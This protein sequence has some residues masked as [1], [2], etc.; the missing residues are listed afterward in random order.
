MALSLLS[1]RPVLAGAA[2]ATGRGR[3]AKGKVRDACARESA[4]LLAR[5]R[6]AARSRAWSCKQN[7]VIAILRAILREVVHPTNNADAHAARPPMC[8]C[9][10]AD[11]DRARIH[12]VV[13]P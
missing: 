9:C 10:F 11:D 3:T 13:W 7:A 5:L 6:A 2:R 8:I 12:R 1:N 4:R